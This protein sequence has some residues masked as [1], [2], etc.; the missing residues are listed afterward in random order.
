MFLTTLRN[1]IP[2]SLRTAVTR[3]SERLHELRFGTVLGKAGELDTAAVQSN[4]PYHYPP[5]ANVQF[6]QLMRSIKINPGRDVFLDY[7]SGIGWTVIL[8]A[9]YPFRK[10]IGI[11]PAS[12]L[13]TIAQQNICE[14]FPRLRCRDIALYTKAPRDFQVPPEVSI[15]YFYSAFTEATLQAVFENIK[16]SIRQFPR[17][18]TILYVAPPGANHLETILERLRWLKEES[19][20]PLGA[21]CTAIL[22]SCGP[23]V[24]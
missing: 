1:A 15:V 22:C 11:E 8:A 7:S 10:V 14:V 6:R 12:E 17:K 24:N 4:A 13:N 21:R 19:R 9:T 3:I 2:G 16:Q 20:E 23:D 18:V 5:V